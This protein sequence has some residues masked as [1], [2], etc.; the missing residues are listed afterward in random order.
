MAFHLDI[1]L[2]PELAP[3]AW[4]IG[5]WAGAG[6]VGYPPIESANFGPEIS[7][8]HDGRP[9]LAGPLILR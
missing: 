6:V 7:C 9:V 3:L 1:D 4:L 8:S 2:P 5:D